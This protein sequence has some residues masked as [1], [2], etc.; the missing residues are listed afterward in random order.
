M[1]FSLTKI[2]RL[3]ANEDTKEP[4]LVFEIDGVPTIFGSTSILNYI[5]IGDDGLFI[6]GSWVIGGLRDIEDQ[7]SLLSTDSSGGTTTKITQTLDHE[8]GR[9]SSVQT[10]TMALIDKNQ[11]ITRLI[12]P[13]GVVEDVLGRR[14][15][16]YLGFNDTGYKTD[17]IPIFKGIIDDISAGPGI[18]RIQIGNSEQK[19]RQ[20][21][22]TKV[23]TNLDGAI[24]ASQ[25]TITVDSTTNFLASG[26]KPDGSP[27][28]AFKRYIRI[29]D[30]L[31]EYTGLTATT[32]TGC[33]RGQLGSVAV[34]HDD[35]TNVDSFYRL[36]DNGVDA[37]LKVMLG[38]W[39]GPFAEDV[40]ITNF[41]YISPS[42]SEVN[43]IYFDG[44]DVEETYGLTSGDYVDSAG[45]V[46][47][48]NNF[49]GRTI[50]SVVKI[51]EGSY[52]IMNGD[53]FVLETGS[54]ALLSFRSQYDTLPVGA[55]L[56]MLPDEVDVAQH[57]R[58]KTLFFSAYSLD[59]YIDDTVNGKDFIETELYLPGSMFS[60]PRKA[61][62]SVQSSSGPIP[63]MDT[64]TLDETNVINPT[65]LFIRRSI[66]KNFYNNVIYKYDKSAIS[67]RFLSSRLTVAAD[68]LAR[69]QVGNRSLIIE[70]K[71]LRTALAAENI[72]TQ[73]SNRRLS[74][75][76]FA[77]EFLENVQI[78]YGVGFS[79][80]IGDIL[81]LDGVELQITDSQ[82]IQRGM[83]PRL[84][85]VI[86]KTIDIKSGQVT[87]NLLDTAYSAQNRYGLIGPSSKVKA[88][89]S[90][91][92]FVIERLYTFSNFATEGDKWSRFKRPFVVVRSVDSS[93]KETA[94]ILSVSG[95]TIRLQTPLGFTPDP[96]YIMEIADYNVST[97]QI[98][99]LYA[100]M[101]DNP[102]F[103][104]GKSQYLML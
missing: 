19:K 46:D 99:L 27:E 51:P 20:E 37:A 10:M 54:P 4:Q 45:A 92:E 22:F 74:R 65:K 13:G 85:E 33:V 59:V 84:F 52:L 83:E 17:F 31:I 86:N 101:Q 36:T 47:A 61:R 62:A 25:S 87:L 29:D 42:Q 68:S 58:L 26:T 40:P 12:S 1:S 23:Q 5:R 6:D 11:A 56:K 69:I 93:I 63:G 72:V 15:K 21:I 95:N 7:Q 80:E 55:A 88:A 18:I 97:E 90:N 73:S 14:A 76:K 66:G 70:S 30:E 91:S 77:A 96:G 67:D 53:D 38:G 3:K 43:A 39:Q 9:G 82:N 75:Y 64:I 24:D 60:V 32:F 41:V 48:A 100:F 44:V 34:S 78:K 8:K 103:A 94:R 102:T 89:I 35:D 49:T 98:K 71:G 81:I 16:V 57:Q 50:Q 104:D 79:V 2:A 28:T